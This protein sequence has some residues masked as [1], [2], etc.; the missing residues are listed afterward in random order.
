ML[1]GNNFVVPY[2]FSAAIRT[3]IAAFLVTRVVLAFIGWL[4]LH[5]FQNL[6]STPGSWEIKAGGEMGPA[7]T[8]LSRDTYPLVNIAA[9]WDSGWYHSVAKNGYAF[10]PGQ[11]SNTA[12]FPAYP[13]LMRAAHVLLPGNTDASWFVAGMIVSNLALLVALAYFLRLVQIDYG[14]E[15]AA[16]AVLYLLVF[17]TAFFFSAVYAESVFVAAI[18]ATFYYARTQRWIAAGICAA[19]ATLARSPG[20]L[21]IVPLGFEYLA[22]RRFRW[23]EI[24]PDILALALIPAALGGLMLYFRA[25]FGNLNAIRDAQAAWAGGWGEFNPPW[26]PLVRFFQQ[27]FVAY[28]LINFGCAVALLTLCVIAALR[29][30]TSYGIYALLSY[31]FV[32]A[33]GSFDSLPRYFLPV[34]PAF[35]VLALAGRRAVF[36]RLYLV[37]SSMLAAFLMVR[38]AL[39]RWVA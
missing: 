8:H 11:Q 31:W 37:S 33:W 10:L 23:R 25:R 19:I 7:V 13:M 17:P 5:S 2:S 30:R 27:P 12:F 28:D 22:Q 24:R 26:Q 3:V 9:R 1:T 34:F 32:T 29:L 14:A 21:L 4:A 16:R 20:I 18:M 38:F 35:I 15:T 39:W 36:D 6:A